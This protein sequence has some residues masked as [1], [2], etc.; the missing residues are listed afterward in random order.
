MKKGKK[1]LSKS[2]KV[3]WEKNILVFA[4]NFFPIFYFDIIL[5]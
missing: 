4:K 3:L 2:M 5:R 1:K